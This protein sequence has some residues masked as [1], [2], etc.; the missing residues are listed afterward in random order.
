MSQSLLDALLDTGC[1]DQI[2]S[3]IYDLRRFFAEIFMPNI[4]FLD[5]S[6]RNLLI[7]KGITM[8]S[9][10]DELARNHACIPVE[11][12]G[13]L[14]KPMEL[15]SPSGKIAELFSEEDL[16]FP[17]LQLEDFRRKQVVGAL[18]R[19]GMKTHGIPW[20]DVLERAQSIANLGEEA[21]R[22]RCKALIDYME[23]KLKD[24]T[25]EYSR[26]IIRELLISTRFLPVMRKPKSCP[27][28]WRADRMVENLVAP[29]D[30][31]LADKKKV[32]CFVECLVESSIIGK[33]P[34]YKSCSVLRF[35]R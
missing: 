5:A 14:K 30:A 21:A 23:T 7:F 11:P 10:I 29:R 1:D 25:D 20:E 35:Q 19:L 13:E 3:R 34:E 8:S 4:T 6:Q 12:T 26:D 2:N 32:L 31:Y 18:E 24:D 33:T 22:K 9:E 16:R 17:Q 15:V 28:P 27:V